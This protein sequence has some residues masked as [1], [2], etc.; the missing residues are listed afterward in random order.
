MNFIIKLSPQVPVGQVQSLV[1]SRRGDT[2]IINGEGLDLSFMTP[3]DLLPPGA[4]DHPLLSGAEIKCTD[5]GPEINGLLFHIDAMQTDPAACF[6]EPI[7]IERDGPVLLPPQVQPP[8]IIPEPGI[9]DE[10]QD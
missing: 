3:G 9:E 7:I 4:I 6:P 5:E 1:I 10:H 8:A 2:L